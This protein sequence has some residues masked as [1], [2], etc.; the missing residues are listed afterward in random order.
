M[1]L[2]RAMNGFALKAYVDQVPAPSLSPG[3]IIL[4][5]NLSFHKV[6]GVR[7]AIETVGATSLYLPPHSQVSI[8]SSR[9]S[10]RPQ[11]MQSVKLKAILRKISARAAE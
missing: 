4:M 9:S 10:P 5:D 2:G 3:D 8:P 7:D 1:V 11:E 6:D